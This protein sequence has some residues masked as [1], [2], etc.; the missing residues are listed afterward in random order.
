MLFSG[1]PENAPSVEQVRCYLQNQRKKH[2]KGNSPAE[3]LQDFSVRHSNKIVYWNFEEGEELHF[4]VALT[5]EVLQQAFDQYGKKVFGLDAVWK[6]TDRRIPVWVVVVD[7]PLKALVV[8]YIVST[9]GDSDTLRKALDKLI[10]TRLRDEAKAMIDHDATELRA[11]SDLQVWLVFTFL[12]L[13]RY[14]HF[15]VV[16]MLL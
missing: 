4:I 9:R 3:L 15:C 5:S 10:P 1:T 11:L 2:L 12:M 14:N 13:F 7:S 8:G 6:Y 16:F